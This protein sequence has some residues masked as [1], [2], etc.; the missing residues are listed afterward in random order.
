MPYVT[1]M[2]STSFAPSCSVYQPPYAP[3]SLEIHCTQSFQ[4]RLIVPRRSRHF[5]AVSVPAYGREKQWWRCRSRRVGSVWGGGVRVA[6][7]NHS[8]FL[9]TTQRCDGPPVRAGVTRTFPGMSGGG[10]GLQ[11]ELRSA[12]RAKVWGRG[13]TAI[14]AEAAFN[15]RM[16]FGLLSSPGTG[17]L[18]GARRL[19]NGPDGLV[20]ARRCNTVI[21]VV[22][23]D[24]MM[25]RYDSQRRGR[26]LRVQPGRQ[27][28]WICS[29]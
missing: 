17:R 20:R 3:R 11:T 8:L 16:Q 18:W 15:S 2:R 21:G 6:F 7:A 13:F 26:P 5:V 24:L 27:S 28:G 19:R 14:G 12:A 9:P 29:D 22:R 1:V 10:G 4:S 25:K 23:Y